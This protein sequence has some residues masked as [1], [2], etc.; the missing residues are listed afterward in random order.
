MILLLSA[1]MALG[2]FK[3]AMVGLSYSQ[4]FLSVWGERPAIL[5]SVF[6]MN[7]IS[8]WS[9]LNFCKDLQRHKEMNKQLSVW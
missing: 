1:K 8:L 3:K 6:K 4:V 9:L 5:I 7:K 2:S